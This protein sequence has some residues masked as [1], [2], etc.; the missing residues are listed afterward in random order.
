MQVI[1]FTKQVS[2]FLWE[3][4]IGK[5]SIKEK[6][7]NCK[8]IIISSAKI[9]KQGLIDFTDYC[10]DKKYRIKAKQKKAYLKI[11]QDLSRALK[12]LKSLDTILHY[13]GWNRQQVRNFWL[14]FYKSGKVRADVFTLIEKQYSEGGQ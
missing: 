9:Y 2:K 10:L 14:E 4:V 12:I 11:Q 5:H 7:I 13:A 8:N 3:Q 1:Y 6:L